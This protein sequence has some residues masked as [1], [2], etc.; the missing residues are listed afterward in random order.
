MKKGLL[1]ALGAFGLWGFLPVYWKLLQTVPAT[2]ILMHRIV[3]S[4]AF[5][6]LILTI[7][8]DWQWIQ[9]VRQ[10]SRIWQIYIAIAGLIAAN[11]FIYI[12]AVNNGF[13][14]ETSLGY[15]INP[16]VSVLLG[17]VFLKEKLRLG[18]WFAVSS[19]AIGVIYL[20]VWYG[21]L[22]WLA[23]ALAFSFGIYGLLKK[24]SKLNALHGL[25]LETMIL[26]PIA[27][28]YLIF[29]EGLGQGQFGHVSFQIDTLLIVSGAITA[30]PLL[31][32]AAA[33]QRI[34]L[35]MVVL[36]QYI[37]P[38]IQLVLG[39]YIY[40]EPFEPQR[41]VGFS[42][43]WLALIIYTVEGI[44]DRRKGILQTRKQALT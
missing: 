39:I 24:T 33:A 34:P 16:L 37:A 7:N 32:F 27:A 15:F 3:W 11:W 5:L 42:F 4:L 8:R 44:M 22:P 36:M 29:I 30:I 28:G 9:I 38:T 12:W 1:Y 35:Y 23:L 18:Q 14:I 21:S 41:L 10:D 2:E 43:V 20:T 17:V 13:I 25:S 31:L 19:A 40:H 6:A 26:F